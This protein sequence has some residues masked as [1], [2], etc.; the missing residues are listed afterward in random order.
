M[1]FDVWQ[2]VNPEAMRTMR[3]HVLDAPHT[4]VGGFLVGQHGEPHEPPRIVAAVEAHDARGDLTSLT[5]THVAWE[6][7]HQ[8]MDDEF[9]DCSVIGWYHSHPGHGIFLSGHDQFIQRNFFSEA[10][11]VAIVI[12][13]VART[14]GFFAWAHD[15]IVLLSERPVGGTAFAPATPAARAAFRNRAPDR[16]PRQRLV[17]TFDDEPVRQPPTATA[18]AVVGHGSQPSVA[19]PRRVIEP[20]A[21]LPTGNPAPPPSYPVAG[22]L[23]PATLGLI[24]GIAVAI[25]TGA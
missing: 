18:S 8:R 7:L 4:E 15:E 21:T 22:H 6:H 2:V 25:V 20:E 13:P 16:R 10:W 9:P 23:I 5:F 1:T 17:V 14:E 24:C 12:D 11:Q 3:E 19:S